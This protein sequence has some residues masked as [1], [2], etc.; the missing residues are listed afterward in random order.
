MPV[1]LAGQ[2]VSPPVGS[3]AGGHAWLSL[4]EHCHLHYEIAVAGLGRP[5]DG[6]VS[7]H[8]HGVAEL[9]ELGARPHQHKRLLK[10]FYGTEVRWARGRDPPRCRRRA[11]GS[12]H[13]PVSLSPRQAQGVVKDLDADLLQHLAQGTAFLQ[14]STKAHPRGEMR[15]RVGPLCTSPS[16]PRGTEQTPG[17][18]TV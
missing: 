4:D 9:G 7:A 16:P 15:G 5:A 2:L 3:G 13:L 12:P 17:S 11:W 14:V 18:R 6:T 10:G 8:L 1:P